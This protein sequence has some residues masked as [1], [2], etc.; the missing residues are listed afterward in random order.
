MTYLYMRFRLPVAGNQGN[1]NR[2]TR[3][4]YPHSNG[5]TWMILLGLDIR[6]QLKRSRIYLRYAVIGFYEFEQTPGQV[7]VDGSDVVYM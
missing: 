2:C 1:S 4:L 7:L 5:Y 3:T 6:S